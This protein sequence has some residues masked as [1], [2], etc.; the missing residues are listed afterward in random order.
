MFKTKWQ[1]KYE[2]AMKNIEY[3]KNYHE[4][5]MKLHID[6]ELLC[7]MHSAQMTAL[8]DTLADMRRIA[9]S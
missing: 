1:K 3:W 4:G 7:T 5:Q 6:S 9:K 8:S 2:Q